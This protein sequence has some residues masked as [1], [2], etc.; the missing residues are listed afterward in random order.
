[1]LVEFQKLVFF[2]F[3]VYW[4]ELAFHKLLVKYSHYFNT[5]L[6]EVVTINRRVTC[7]ILAKY[8][9]INFPAK[10]F[11]FQLGKTLSVDKKLKL[12][13]HSVKHE[14]Q[15]R[16]KPGKAKTKFYFVERAKFYCEGRAKIKF[17]CMER[18]KTKFFCCVERAKLKFYCMDR[19]KMKFYCVERAKTKFCCVE[20]TKFCGDCPRV[21]TQVK[22]EP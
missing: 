21:Q 1:M 14:N 11:F 7:Q 2:P 3:K 19:A 15:I 22:E 9:P 17:N 10:T 4:K 5:E 6:I 16:P 18:A 13:G 20:R 8:L 12:K